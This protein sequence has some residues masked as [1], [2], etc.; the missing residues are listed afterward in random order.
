MEEKIDHI[1]RLL[2]ELNAKIDNFLGY[3]DLSG[4]EK[5]EIESIIRETELEGTVPYDEIL[6]NMP[7]P[8]KVTLTRNAARSI[9]GLPDNQRVK[10]HAIIEKLKDNPFS[11]PYRK[12][13]GMEHTYRFRMGEFRILFQ[14]NELA[15]AIMVI[16]I[17]RR[18][19]AY[20]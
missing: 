17:D 2:L 9:E 4:Q 16:K 7:V 6:W 19:N 10:F 8:Y 18:E 3:E 15:H 11:Y 1:E 20:Q 14:V 12:I 13:R 5:R